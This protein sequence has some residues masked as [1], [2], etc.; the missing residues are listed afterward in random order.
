[1]AAIT[2][3]VAALGNA[4]AGLKGP[5]LDALKELAEVLKD[6]GRAVEVSLLQPLKLVADALKVAVAPPLKLVA[7][8]LKAVG[9]SAKWLAGQWSEVSTAV[10]AVGTV[11]AGVGAML[12]GAAAPALALFTISLSAVA[13]RIGSEFLP[14]LAAA[15]KTLLDVGMGVGRLA[16]Q[17]AGKLVSALGAVASFAGKAAEQAIS[18]GQSL[19]QMVAKANPVAFAQFQLAVDDTVAVLGQAL[20]PI[21]RIVTDVVRAAGDTL[22][23]FASSVGNS[24]GAILRPLGEVVKV[25]FDLAGR[26]GQAFAGLLEIVAPHLATLGEVFVAVAEAVAPLV[27]LLVE[28]VGGALGEALKLLGGLLEMVI[29]PVLGLARAVG[30][31]VK[32]VVEGVKSLLSMVGIDLPGSKPGTEKDGSRGAAVRSASTTDIDSVLRKARENAFSYGKAAGEDLPKKT[33]STMESMKLRADEIYKWISN[34]LPNIL[35]RMPF[36]LAKAIAGGAADAASAAGDYLGDKADDLGASLGVV[37]PSAKLDIG[38]LSAADRAGAMA[39]AR[40]YRETGSVE[41]ALKAAS[42][43]RARAGTDG[44]GTVTPRVT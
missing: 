13:A 11:A 32:W 12:A 1:V 28:L 8:G 36:D 4:G 18:L 38:R 30:D 16:G 43:A 42:E 14:Q 6:V 40:T 5:A 31:L 37:D 35:V 29:P 41:A 19:G 34:D 21:F 25:V 44:S 3:P 7:D 17:F 22:V 20:L 33:L 27:T 10:F 26:I 24:V 2:A 39:G 15:G 23:T 9:E